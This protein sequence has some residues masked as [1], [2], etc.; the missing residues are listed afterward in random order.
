MSRP[1]D[2]ITCRFVPEVMHTYYDEDDIE[3]DTDEGCPDGGYCICSECGFPMLAGEI[4]WFN[5]SEGP[6]GGIIYEPRFNYCP[7]CGAKVER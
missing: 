4:G 3:H 1:S 7:N 2:G 6:H 5:E